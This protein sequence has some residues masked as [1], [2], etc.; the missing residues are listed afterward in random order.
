MSTANRLAFASI[1]YFQTIATYFTRAYLHQLG[2]DLPFFL[3]ISTIPDVLES[4]VLR[5]S[6]H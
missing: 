6:M 4:S 3:R 2:H 5:F 1:F